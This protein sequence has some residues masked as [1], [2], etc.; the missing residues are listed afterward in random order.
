MDTFHAVLFTHHFSVTFSCLKNEEINK[1]RGFW[2]FNN[3]LI[4]NEE[5][6]HQIKKLISDTLNELFRQNILDDQVKLE[7]F[8]YNFRN[9][10]Y[11]INFPK[12]VTK[13]TNKK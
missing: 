7:Y 3:I 6:I 1:G 2:K 9:Y 12:K 11:T 8:K 4:E 5:Y 13:E 10:K